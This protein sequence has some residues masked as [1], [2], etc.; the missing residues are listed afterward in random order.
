MLLS[1]QAA[2]EAI[3][4]G[5]KTGPI[6]VEGL[7]DLSQF[8]RQSLPAG[9][10]CYELDARGSKLAS[11]PP[12]LKIDGRL[13]LDDCA[14]LTSL[15]H[16]LTAG[17]ISLRNC[18]SLRAL[19]E[20]L[21][22]WFLDMTGCSSFET[23]P[24]SGTIHSGSLILRNCIGIRSLPD[25]IGR[26]SQLDL[27]GCVQ[28]GTIP[29]NISVSG[30]V[31]IGGTGIASLPARLRGAPLRWR[32][33]RI[34]ERIAFHPEQL[35]A[36]EALAEKNA[37]RRRVIIERMGY[38]RFS[39]E[40]K[41]KVLDEDEDRAGKR[42]LLSIDLKEDEPL[43]GLSCRCPSTGRQYLLR[44]PPQTK[45]CH[46]AAAWIAGFDDPSRYHPVIET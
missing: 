37:E 40:A 41:A 46:Q 35:S 19:P 44:V 43:V 23:W 34:D 2:S 12:D 21:N 1:P 18:K 9:L 4:S 30:W 24:V 39:Q 42:Q 14:A 31:D 3:R 38:L 5:G 36:R 45:T 22:T 11:L 27:A 28:I 29:E 10:H 20:E 6:T 17:S 8:D 32:G 33:V 16:R 15:P 25:W 26:L 13:V 7:L